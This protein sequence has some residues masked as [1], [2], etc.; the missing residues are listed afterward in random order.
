MDED[1]YYKWVG[2]EEDNDSPEPPDFNEQKPA[3]RVDTPDP[4]KQLAGNSEE[5]PF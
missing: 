5:D 4:W 3:W 1:E 2:D